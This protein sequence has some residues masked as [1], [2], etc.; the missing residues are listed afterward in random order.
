VKDIF[1]STYAYACGHP[2]APK[3][4]PLYFYSD[5]LIAYLHFSETI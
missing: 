3:S 1:R 5:L 2:F 4:M